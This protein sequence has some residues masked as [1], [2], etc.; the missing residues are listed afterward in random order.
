MS[1]RIPRKP[2]FHLTFRHFES[3][4]STKV[5]WKEENRIYSVKIFERAPE[6]NQ[7]LATH[8]CQRRNG[9]CAGFCFPHS[10]YTRVCGCPFGQKLN[11]V[12]LRSCVANPDE[13]PVPVTCSS[14][15]FSCDNGRCVLLRQRCDGANDCMD[16]SDESG[17]AGWIL[18]QP[19]IHFS[20]S[21]F[22]CL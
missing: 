1:R 15:T 2:R 6:I 17:C 3:I 10:S 5:L 14:S 21:C 12:D 18:K 7:I 11:S 19:Y 22:S 8:P 13:T 16:G 9:D 4:F 20:Q